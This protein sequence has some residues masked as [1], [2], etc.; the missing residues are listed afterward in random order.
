M[1]LRFILKPNVTSA[2]CS[3]RILTRDGNMLK[4]LPH[5]Y[6]DSQVEV[7]ENCDKRIQSL[8]SRLL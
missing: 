7:L 4:K 6:G 3:E 2:C 8:F 1:A 5:R